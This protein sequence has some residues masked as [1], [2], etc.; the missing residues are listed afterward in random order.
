MLNE[1]LTFHVLV[2]KFNLSNAVESWASSQLTEVF[3][4]SSHA[5]ILKT[6]LFKRIA[7]QKFKYCI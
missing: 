7:L 6:A 1:K 5:A 4:A 3:Q 2:I